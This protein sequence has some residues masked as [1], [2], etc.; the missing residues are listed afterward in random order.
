MKRSL[1]KGCNGGKQCHN[2][3]KIVYSLAQVPIDSLKN[4]TQK[5]SMPI[6]WA[7]PPPTNSDHNLKHKKA[8]ENLVGSLIF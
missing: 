3:K 5:K 2:G 6:G 1:V 4:L 8:Q 7:L